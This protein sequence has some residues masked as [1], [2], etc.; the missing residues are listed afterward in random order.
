MSKISEKKR[1]QQR[2]KLRVRKKI[3]GTAARP[4][5]SLFKG[6]RN[7]YA[8]VIDDDK[9]HT[10]ASVS[11]HEKPFKKL[12]VNVDNAAKIGE[13][14]GIKLK[15]LNIQEIVFDRNGMLYHG[16]IKAFADGARK[17]GIKF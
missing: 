2:R 6:N 5:L 7:I 1:K 17:S 8:Q 9:G 11:T 15:E 3:I 14:L 16:V 4:R 12:R 10:M 13:A